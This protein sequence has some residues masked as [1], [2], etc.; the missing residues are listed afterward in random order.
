MGTYHQAD[1]ALF[2]MNIH[3]NA[4]LRASLYL[5]LFPA[6]WLSKHFVRIF[7]KQ[8]GVILLLCCMAFIGPIPVMAHLYGLTP[9]SGSA[10]LLTYVCFFIVLHQSFYIANINIARGMVP[11]IADE[12]RIVFSSYIR[13]RYDGEQDRELTRQFIRAVRRFKPRYRQPPDALATA[14]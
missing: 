12:L 3:N 4:K 10:G 2:Y 14:G 8:R 1:Y 7:D 6:A 5:C 13:L 11:D 9:P